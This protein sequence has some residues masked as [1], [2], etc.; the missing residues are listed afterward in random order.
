MYHAMVAPNLIRVFVEDIKRGKINT[1]AAGKKL[2][3]QCECGIFNPIRA[4]ELL[5][6]MVAR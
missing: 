1:K 5:K 4:A 6:A 3:R 2:S